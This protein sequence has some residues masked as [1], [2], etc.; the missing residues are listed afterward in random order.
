MID[1]ALLLDANAFKLLRPVR[2]R[3]GLPSACADMSMCACA[4]ACD[5][6]SRLERAESAL[7][8]AQATSR[9]ESDRATKLLQEAATL[10]LNLEQVRCNVYSVHISLWCMLL[11][12][13]RMQLRRVIKVRLP[14]CA[15]VL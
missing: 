4:L 2:V 6:M 10:R 15:P 1:F 3:P 7:L 11:F 8:E 12:F 13:E 14:L 9:R 5:C